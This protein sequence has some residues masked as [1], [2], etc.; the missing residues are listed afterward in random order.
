MTRAPPPPAPPQCALWIR[1]TGHVA[2]TERGRCGAESES[3]GLGRGAQAAKH[4]ERPALGQAQR[5]DH[6]RCSRLPLG[7]VVTAGP[8]LLRPLHAATDG[9]VAAVADSFGGVLA[10]QLG[11]GARQPA[12][13]QQAGRPL[14]GR[15]A[16]LAAAIALRLERQRQQHHQ[17]P[18]NAATATVIGP[19]RAPAGLRSTV[20]DG[21]DG[22]V[23]CRLQ[24]QLDRSGL[25][26]QWRIPT[27]LHQQTK[28]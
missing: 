16:A 6:R 19:A 8:T 14:R 9:L 17:A 26:P 22:R 7:I 18:A 23:G 12:V 4:S 15:A 10:Q 28:L 5:S 1:Q 3:L 11:R 2:A 24:Q 21:G 25:Y 20:V 27:V 13:A